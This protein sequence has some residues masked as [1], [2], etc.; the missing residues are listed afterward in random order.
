MPTVTS[1]AKIPPVPYGFGRE[2]YYVPAPDYVLAPKSVGDEAD[3]PNDRHGILDALGISRDELTRYEDFHEYAGA[4]TF[5]VW[6]G[7]SR[8]GMTCLFVAVPV[9]GIREGN[10]ADDCS[11][12]GMDAIAELGMGGDGLTQFVFEGDHVDVYVYER[13]ADLP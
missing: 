13:A 1:T 10:S 8:Y 12:E 4:S 9:Q 5:N 6:S 11:P 3:A 7:E 2:Y